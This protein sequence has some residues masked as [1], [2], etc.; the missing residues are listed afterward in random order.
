M[1]D[2]VNWDDFDS[3]AFAK[4]QAKGDTYTGRIVGLRAGT[5]F[6]GNP[7]PVIDIE[8]ADG[9]PLTISCGQAALKA[10][11]RQ[12]G[13]DGELTVGRVITVTMTGEVK[14]ERG[15]KKTFD[16]QVRDAVGAAAQADKP[17]F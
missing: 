6:N 12:L 3:G 14:A 7:C 13:K 10:T 2:S 15:M 16:V 8:Q 4:F 1:S 5:D 17:P 11:V 9:T